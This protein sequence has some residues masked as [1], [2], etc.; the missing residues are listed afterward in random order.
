LFFDPGGSFLPEG[1]TF[2]YG[3][4]REIVNYLGNALAFLSEDD[5]WKRA[6]ELYKEIMDS[7]WPILEYG[8]STVSLSKPFSWYQKEAERQPKY[9]WD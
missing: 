2:E 1:F 4:P 9:R 5:A 7:E 3:N 8:I 6:K